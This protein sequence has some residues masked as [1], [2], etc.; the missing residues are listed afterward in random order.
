MQPGLN[1][2]LTFP[3]VE[4]VVLASVWFQPI[5]PDPRECQLEIALTL[6]ININSRV[7]ALLAGTHFNK[8]NVIYLHLL[9]SVLLD[10]LCV[11]Y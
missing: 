9:M 5:P 4:L 1:P 11:H 6:F 3:A 8:T 7:F 2:Y 10:I